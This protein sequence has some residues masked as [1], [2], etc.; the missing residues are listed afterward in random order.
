MTCGR[1]ERAFLPPPRH[2]PIHQSRIELSARFRT[3]AQSLHDTRTIAFDESVTVSDQLQCGALARGCFQVQGHDALGTVEM[4]VTL[5]H[6]FC[7]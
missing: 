4:T 2:P 5:H 6:H 1:C 7:R 3:K